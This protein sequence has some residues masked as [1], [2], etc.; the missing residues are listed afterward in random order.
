MRKL[1]AI[2]LFE[3][4][5]HLQ[6]PLFYVLT[7]VMALLSFGFMASDAITS[8]VGN[9]HINSP[10][11]IV[12]LL[13]GLTVFAMFVIT[14]FV[15][16]A[17]QRDFELSTAGLFFSKPVSKVAY[18][19]GRLLGSLAVSILVFVG[20]CLGLLVATTMPWI[21]AEQLGP[22]SLTPFV[23]AFGLVIL[24]NL[25]FLAALFF[26][27]AALSRS[28]LLTY[29]AVVVFFGA[30]MAAGLLLQDVENRMIASLVDPFGSTA[31]D[32]ATR[33]W[34][35]EEKN[36]LLPTLAEGGI[37]LNRVIWT[38]AGLALFAAT[39]FV[40][41]PARG[42]R[43]SRRRRKLPADATAAPSAPL[44]AFRQVTQSFSTAGYFRQFLRQAR[45]E[46]SSTVKSV[47]LLVLL[48][49]A[50]GFTILTLAVSDQLYGTGV[51]PVT[52]IMLD[53][54][55]MFVVML[56][57]IATF[58][59]GELVW[60][61]RSVKL[62]E[63]YDSLPVPTAAI[64]SAKIV[65]LMVVMM[66]F[67][68]VGALTLIGYQIFKGYYH[69]EL[70]LY[71]SSLLLSVY[72]FLLIAVLAV[73]LQVLTNNKFMGYL[74]MILYLVSRFVLSAL[75]LNHNLYRYAG[76]PN[77][78]YSDMNGFGHFLEGM[79]WFSLYWTF[80]ALVLYGLSLALKLRGTEGSRTARVRQ[81]RERLRGPARALVAVGLLAFIATGAFIFYNTNVLNEY[82]PPDEQM[83]LQ[84]SYEKK[85]RRYKDISMPR[86]VVVHTEVDIFPEERRMEARG[87]YRLRN[88]TS[89]P[90]RE[91]HMNLDTR[92]DLKRLVLP[93]HKRTLHDEKLGY[94]IYRLD[95]P[96]APGEEVTLEF[97]VE[98]K[99]PG[100]VNSG[101]DTN[102]VH[103]GTFF[104]NAHYFP[105]FGYQEGAQLT[106]RNE[107][108][109]RGL[110]PVIRMAKLE[111]QKARRNNYITR[112]SDWIDFETVVS[113]SPDQTAI[114]PG[115][116]QREWTQNGRRYFHYKMDAPILHFYSYLSADYTVKRDR[117]KD[118]NIEV[119]YHEPHSFNVDRM[120]D[121]VKK[122]LD[123]FT[124]NFGPYQHRQVRILE[125]P[126][127]ASFAQSFAN[128]IP[129]SEGIGFIA[130]LRDEEAI[131]YVFYITA[132]EVAHQWWAHQVIGANVQGATML[133]ESMSQY[134]SLMV[135]EK[136]Y[137][138]DKMRRFLKYELDQYLTGRS[139][140]RVEEM[141]LMRVENQQ[142]IHYRK[143]S[144]ILYALRDYIGEEALNRALSRY[145]Q[146]VKFQ[147]PPYTTTA[148]LMPYLEEATPPHLRSILDDMFRTI[149]LFENRVTAATYR[150]RA[151]GKYD[152]HLT[153]VAKKVR[154][155][156]K[157][158]TTPAPINDW[159]DIGVFAE[160]KEGGKEEEIP[161]YLKKH[162]L[163]QPITRLQLVVDRVPARAGIDP[164][165]KLVDRDSN[166]N[167][168]SVTEASGKAAASR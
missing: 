104:N 137:G 116:L 56:I 53:L 6:Q 66:A 138:R 108:R 10:F 125:F 14:V 57:I 22:F 77:A 111:D 96:L 165:N 5:Y 120:I 81:F 100:F 159:I 151:D 45:I 150:R 139:A 92:V 152:V 26:S 164:Y 130:D 93:A 121:A 156:G 157:G 90:V 87:R 112:D 55:G 102:L 16:S 126:R 129:Y 118:V 19:G 25:I 54:Q 155:G 103:N 166:D 28:L 141:P 83:D 163:T 134:A 67:L 99:N 21:E 70:G 117:W 71:L 154:D 36:T 79:F 7:G 39:M 27:L 109:K 75:D 91:L 63:V 86:I 64:L 47:L 162:H 12:T 13:A 48:L 131:D 69:F 3:I 32:L 149:T 106:D 33:Y 72:P 35:V 127:Y 18:L 133:S 97:E 89:G 135:M 73:F 23:W 113:T 2:A 74:L 136:E 101:S 144:L 51:Y 62:N 11:M 78:P 145:V 119:Y 17:A 61:E 98:V 60:K 115:Y 31:I 124:A 128:T 105:Y 50:I 30:N 52:S 24:P 46:V 148:E 44:T 76:R 122:S 153:V 41:D 114:A 132:H 8:S 65:A 58:Y 146:A 158:E 42:A 82:V 80:F 143:G 88:K 9:V 68:G 147:E 140:E 85:F 142:Y 37:G 29:V 167:R 20:C 84:A 4:R 49:I 123:Y 34:T 43:A 95:Q 110:P 59:S 1:A 40:F 15:A 168:K 160:E 161:L 94:S 107:R 38:L